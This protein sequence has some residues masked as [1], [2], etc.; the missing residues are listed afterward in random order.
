MTTDAPTCYGRAAVQAPISTF[1]DTIVACATAPGEAAVAI[2]RLSGPQARD[3]GQGLA[4]GPRRSHVLHR[5]TVVDADGTRLDDALV[6]EMR[7]PRSYTG[8]D[9]VELHLHGARYLV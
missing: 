5:A 9:V 4:A 8:E 7:G 3:I 1:S 2:V 6:C